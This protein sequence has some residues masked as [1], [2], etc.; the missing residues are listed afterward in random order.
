MHSSQAYAI[1]AEPVINFQCL[2]PLY[3]ATN[4]PRS[5]SA[6]TIGRQVTRTAKNIDPEAWWYKRHAAADTD[7]RQLL[8]SNDADSL[9]PLKGLHIAPQSCMR[10][11]R[12][13][14]HPQGGRGRTERSAKSKQQSDR[15]VLTMIA[16]SDTVTVIGDV[17]TG[18]GNSCVLS[19]SGRPSPFYQSEAISS[20]KTRLGPPDRVAAIRSGVPRVGGAYNPRFDVG[21]KIPQLTCKYAAQSVPMI[22]SK[23]R[24]VSRLWDTRFLLLA[25][26]GP[27]VCVAKLPTGQ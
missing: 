10:Q 16:I 23:T 2:M 19:P 24:E 20:S 6:I 4:V 1:L 27:P 25:G 7:S 5:S 22:G 21:P 8:Y 17:L 26:V 18:N 3:I 11:T 14:G 15:G 13:N 9:V 12:E